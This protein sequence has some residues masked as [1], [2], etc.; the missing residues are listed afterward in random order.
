MD[1]NIPQYLCKDPKCGCSTH[2]PSTMEA[3]SGGPL[4]L[5]GQIV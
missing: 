2:N 1:L 4:R 5:A 3:E